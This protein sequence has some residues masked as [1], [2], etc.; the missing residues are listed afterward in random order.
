MSSIVKLQGMHAATASSVGWIQAAG[1]GPQRAMLELPG[2]RFLI[3]AGGALARH[4]QS[5]KLVG[6]LPQSLVVGYFGDPMH[7]G[8]RVIARHNYLLVVAALDL[9]LEMIQ[10]R[11]RRVPRS[12]LYSS[13]VSG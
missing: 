8:V 3:A 5:G 11:S 6:K 1:Q 4:E 7:D 2:L 10:V 9:Y 13:T 12:F